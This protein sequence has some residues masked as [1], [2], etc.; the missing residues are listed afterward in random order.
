MSQRP[1][2]LNIVRARPNLPKIAPLMH[3]MWR[4]PAIDAIAMEMPVI[5]L[6]TH[7]L[8]NA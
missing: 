8:S 2:I 7:G 6:C 5:F 3:E 4:R 1:K